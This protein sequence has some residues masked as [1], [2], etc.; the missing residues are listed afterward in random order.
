[1][2]IALEQF[3]KSVS[4]SGILSGREMEAVRSAMASQ[5]LEV[6]DFAR[7]LVNKGKLTIFQA[8]NIVA[9]GA[10][11]LVLG[12]YVILD[13]LGAGGMGTVYKAQHRRMKRVVALKVLP[14]AK[15]SKPGMVERFQREV[16]A[17][18]K[19][20]HPNV[21][22]AHDA[23]EHRG[24]HYLVMEFV[25]GF[26]LAYLVDRCG[27]LP[28]ESVDWIIQVANGLNYAH[29]QGVVH[30]DI[31]PANLLLD[32]GGTVKIL[33][34]G[35]ARFEE[36]ADGNEE[37]QSGLT[38]MGEIIGTLDFMSPEQAEDTRRADA[39]SDIYSLGCTLYY[40]LTAQYLFPEETVLKKLLAH[41]TNPVPSLRAICPDVSES[42]DLF[43]QQ[44]VAKSPDDR[45]QTMGAVIEALQEERRQDPATSQSKQGIIDLLGPLEE[46]R[47][48][49]GRI[50][51]QRET[52]QMMRTKPVTTPVT[53][54]QPTTS[55]DVNE[56]IQ[57][58]E[59]DAGGGRNKSSQRRSDRRKAEP[60]RPTPRD[61]D[62]T[63]L[64]L[65]LACKCGAV[66]AA[67]G[68]LAGKVLS[69]PSCSGKIPIPDPKKRVAGE[70][71]DVQCACGARFFA[72]GGAFGK[73]LKCRQCRKPVS[74]PNPKSRAVSCKKCGQRF[75]ASQSLAGKTVACP[76]CSG[77]IKVP[78]L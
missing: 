23:D 63:T 55:T 60:S 45:P 58:V 30:R 39:R 43:F 72:A 8:R 21:V 56:L 49:E 36:Q 41:R 15:M 1:M 73:T 61:P 25:D 17:A 68:K 3:V 13:K 10:N 29:N 78:P 75:A 52:E 69:C 31:K 66:F 59:N 11:R 26:D 16:E 50:R 22:T 18:A 24:L 28:T 62:T 46:E 74:I 4:D 77:A 67:P 5:P 65:V 48:S 53:S 71:A 34:M 6:Q 44:M 2:A 64:S 7:E 9:G 35:L 27:R 20:D 51:E 14:T 70:Y 42:L 76:S 19:L 38:Q 33:D 12:S 32:T 40:L 57:G 47:R 54:K 37:D